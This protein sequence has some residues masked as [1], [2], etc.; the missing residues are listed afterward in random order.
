MMFIS[1]VNID[2]RELRIDPLKRQLTTFCSYLL[3]YCKNL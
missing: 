2:R 1:D 3:Q